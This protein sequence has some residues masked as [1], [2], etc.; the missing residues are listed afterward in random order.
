[1]KRASRL[2]RRL[3]LVAVDLESGR[4]VVLHEGPVLPAARAT[5]AVPAVLPPEEIGGRWLV[6]GGLVSV[7]PVDVAAMADPDVVLAVEVGAPRARRLPWLARTG[8][9]LG[10][11]VPNPFT[12]KSSFE[13][14]V[15]AAEIALDRQNTLAAAM[16]GPEVLVRVDLGDIGL[17]DFHRLEDAVAAGRRAMES[18]LP[19]LRVALESRPS[20]R[21]ALR[22]RALV[23]QFD[24][25]CDMVVNPHR[26]VAIMELD[27]R[28]IY[29]CSTS[30]RDA[31]ARAAA[32][33]RVDARGQ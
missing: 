18:A 11:M 19:A 4:R 30:C 33:D 12:A 3:A 23:L 17:R 7:L 24:P 5:C 14:L 6:D 31:F 16:V 32:V 20:A 10:R 25:V 8:W 21:E 1:M 13:I 9:R 27:G 26:A 28:T 2:K 22:H 29:F 15:R